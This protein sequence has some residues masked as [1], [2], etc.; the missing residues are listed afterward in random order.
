VGDKDKFNTSIGGTCCCINHQTTSI[1]GDGIC[2]ANVGE[3]TANCPQDCG[4]TNCVNKIDFPFSDSGQQ[5]CAGLVREVKNFCVP[6]TSQGGGGCSSSYVCEKPPVCG[7][8]ICEYGETLDNC[9]QDCTSSCKEEGQ[10]CEA[11]TAG[12]AA[13]CGYDCTCAQS[14][15]CVTKN[16]CGNGV[17][18]QPG[19]DAGLCPQDCGNNVTPNGEPQCYATGG[20]W[21]FIGCRDCVFS[22]KQERISNPVNPRKNCTLT[23]CFQG[24]GCACP[25]GKYWGSRE[26]GCVAFAAGIC[27]N[28]VCEAGETVENCRA[29]CDHDAPTTACVGEGKPI[30]SVNEL[31]CCPG[32]APHGLICVKT[33][34]GDGICD[35]GETASSCPKD[36]GCKRNGDSCC[37]STGCVQKDASF[38]GQYWDFT[39]A[40]QA[41]EFWSCQIDAN[42]KCAPIY[43]GCLQANW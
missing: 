38:G 8:E 37:S 35:T 9:P 26:E 19:E 4:Q 39:G 17:C 40:C 29:D 11:G 42:G 14:G 43:D 2:D 18:E 24:F 10:K 12:S 31:S 23:D 36:C 6:G 30:D 32:L 34:C 41:K 1:C 3:T 22:T 7:N 21:D 28:G 20:K 13:G 25:S 27:G 15:I 33:V 5:C 16:I